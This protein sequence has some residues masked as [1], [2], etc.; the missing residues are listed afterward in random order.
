MLESIMVSVAQERI[1][2][3]RGVLIET[4]LLTGETLSRYYENFRLFEESLASQQKVPYQEG[5]LFLLPGDNIIF[6]CPLSIFSDLESLTE[7][8]SLPVC[9]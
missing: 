8:I 7:S 4:G 2:W 3:I 1:L 6:D 9:W 5:I